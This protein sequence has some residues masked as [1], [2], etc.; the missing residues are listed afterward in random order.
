MKE[1]HNILNLPQD[2]V[3]DLSPGRRIET[4][5][6][7]FDLA[8]IKEV[9]FNSVEIGPFKTEEIGQYYTN[10]IGSH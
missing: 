5:Q 9:H 6:G 4:E 1:N 2:L 7:W 8:S 10:S 3:D